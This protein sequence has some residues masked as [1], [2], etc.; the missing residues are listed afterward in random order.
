MRRDARRRRRAPPAGRRASCARARRRAGRRHQ[1]RRVRGA[2]AVEVGAVLAAELDHVLEPG[3]GHERRCARRGPRAA[4]S[5]PR[6]CRGRTPRRRRRSASARSSALRTAASTPSDWSSGVVGAFAVYSRPPAAS[7]ASVNVPPTSTPSSM[8]AGKLS[9]L[10]ARVSAPNAAWIVLRSRPGAGATG[11]SRC[12]AAACAG[13]ACRGAWSRGTP[14]GPVDR[15]AS[16]VVLGERHVA[17]D[18]LV[19]AELRRHREVDRGC[20]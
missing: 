16:E 18:D 3:G 20:R 4:R 13:T 11:S 5:W 6:S 8:G 10:R 7:T 12:A 14:A 19:D 17:V 2:Q 1:R 15:R 9:A